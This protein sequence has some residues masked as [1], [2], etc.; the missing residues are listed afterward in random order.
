M[1]AGN[2]GWSG[3]QPLG[4]GVVGLE[5]EDRRLGV[6]F[7]GVVYSIQGVGFGAQCFKICGRRCRV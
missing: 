5:F 6:G 4:F 3:G 1:E 7:Q 2:A